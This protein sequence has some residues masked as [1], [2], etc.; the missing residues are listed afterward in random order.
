MFRVESLDTRRHATNWSGLR[1]YDAL[2]LHKTPPLIMSIP[3]IYIYIYIYV[4]VCVCFTWN[5]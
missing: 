1:V 3:D 5:I 2:P 4:C